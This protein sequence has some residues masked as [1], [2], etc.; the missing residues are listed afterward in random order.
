MLSNAPFVTSHSLKVGLPRSS[1]TES[2][3]P[4]AVGWCL[5]SL[6]LSILASVNNEGQ[7]PVS[8]QTERYL[9]TSQHPI[10]IARIFLDPTFRQLEHSNLGIVARDED[11]TLIKR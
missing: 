6:I 1:E 9:L 7:L 2:R 3:R 4:F 8:K 10:G 5:S 11:L